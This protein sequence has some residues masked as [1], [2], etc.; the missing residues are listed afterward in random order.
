MDEAEQ[1]AGPSAPDFEQTE[2]D[3]AA[4]TI[5]TYGELCA[6]IERWREEYFGAC[7]TIAAMHAAAMG[8]QS[9][10]IR[11]VVEDVQDLRYAADAVGA[12]C[13]KLKRLGYEMVAELSDDSPASTAWR[14]FLRRSSEEG[15]IVPAA[16][17]VG[18]K[19]RTI[20][21]VIEADTSNLV[22]ALGEA[23]EALARRFDAEA[24]RVNGI[25]LY[26]S[27]YVLERHRRYL[28]NPNP[29]GRASARVEP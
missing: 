26:G 4:E 29:A 23:K 14:A 25:P 27:M 9:D 2:H 6:E 21:V 22:A 3:P 13:D 7:Q 24:T 19:A 15:R 11:G 16:E 8:R 28:P 12:R 18:S 1:C 10:P 17:T 20:T 5:P